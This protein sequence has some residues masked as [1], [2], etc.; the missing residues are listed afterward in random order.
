MHV[1][2]A[3]NVND[4]YRKGLV[5]LMEHGEKQSSRAGE[6]IVAPM[7]VTTAYSRPMERVLF[8]PQRDAN[9]FFHLFEAL[10]MLSGAN[11][12]RWLDLFVKD[13][14]ARF[15]EE[16]GVQHGAYGYRWRQW[17]RFDQLY[18]IIALL[19]ANP[20][21]RRIVL[22]MWD[23]ANDL[24]ARDKKDI[25]CNTH[26]YFRICNNDTEPVLNMTVCCRSNDA[27]WGAYGANAVHFSVLLEYMA[28]KIG[29]GVGRY[30]QISNNFHVYTSVLQKV[31][32]LSEETNIYQNINP[33]WQPMVTYP[34]GFDHD[35]LMFVDWTR[36]SH[37]LI[38]TPSFSNQWFSDT[39]CPLY[40]A[41]VLWRQK[42]RE[43]AYQ[44]VS[45]SNRMAADWRLAAHMWMKRRMEKTSGKS[46]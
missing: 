45:D 26:V 29:M 36:D 42:L 44:L 34:G 17:W 12:A 32:P 39:A 19:R 43:E 37:T 4:A 46:E 27:V 18:V 15:A 2:D 24:G 41:A 21:D 33:S 38:E 5:F 3:F 9:P 13:F 8:D 25:P 1:I 35:L 16:D 23:P 14:S 31:L 22:T 10:W 40:L 28:A 6:V 20:D 11:D 7:P 30:Y